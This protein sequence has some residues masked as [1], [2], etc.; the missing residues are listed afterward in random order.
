MLSSLIKKRLVALTP[1]KGLSL[2]Q[3]GKSNIVFSA[4][5]YLMAQAKYLQPCAESSDLRGGFK[6]SILMII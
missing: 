1:D 5:I 6:N 2:N 3:Q 4:Y